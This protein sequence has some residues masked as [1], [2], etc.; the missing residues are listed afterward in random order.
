[1]T[2]LEY[3]L[4]NDILVKLMFAVKYQDLLKRLVAVLLS[5]NYEDIEQFDVKKSEMPP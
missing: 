3:T 5:I 4:K 1:M 2:K